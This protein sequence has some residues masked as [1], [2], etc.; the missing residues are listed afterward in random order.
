M[1]QAQVQE[2]NEILIPVSSY[3][4]GREFEHLGN[5]GKYLALK[6]LVNQGF[7]PVYMPQLADSRVN[8]NLLWNRFYHAPSMIATGRMNNE[9]MVVFSHKDNYFS[10]PDNIKASINQGLVN[11]A[12]KI[13]Q[14]EFKSMVDQD[15]ITD[16]QGNRLVYVLKGKEYQKFKDSKSGEIKVKHALEH[17]QTIP[18][19]GGEE[20]AKRYLARHKEV[21]GDKIGIWHSDDLADNPLAHVLCLGYGCS[22]SLYGDGL[23]NYAHFVGVRDAEGAQKIFRPSLEQILKALEGKCIPT[24]SIEVARSELS[25]FYR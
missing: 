3:L 24:S 5:N 23:S 19:L 20:R 12:G 14:P 6:E 16:E 17:P 13:P 18:F 8:G 10:N 15:Q 2:E 1:P 11:Y 25:P 4:R 7:R 21:F 9:P 22:G